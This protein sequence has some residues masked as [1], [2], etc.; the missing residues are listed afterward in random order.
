[1]VYI[2]GG[3]LF[4][5]F[6]R[7]VSGVEMIFNYEFWKGFLF[8]VKVRIWKISRENILY[9]FIIFLFGFNFLV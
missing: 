4:L 5:R 7:G 9:M 6:Y 3:I 1:M 8:F 2:V